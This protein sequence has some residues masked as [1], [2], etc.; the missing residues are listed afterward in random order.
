MNLQ[1]IDVHRLTILWQASGGNPQ[2]KSLVENELQKRIAS[3]TNFSREYLFK[4]SKVQ[5]HEITIS[6]IPTTNSFNEYGA[7][8]TVDLLLSDIEMEE[9][10]RNYSSNPPINTNGQLRA[11]ALVKDKLNENQLSRLEN[12]GFHTSEILEVLHL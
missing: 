9:L 10:L 2:F 11:K 6:F 3:N 1:E 4:V 8:V 7:N 12:I 5:N